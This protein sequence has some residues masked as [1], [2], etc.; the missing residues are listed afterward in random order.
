MKFPIIATS[1]C[2]LFYSCAGDPHHFPYTENVL[3]EGMVITA[4]TAHGILSI[5]GDTESWRKFSNEGWTATRRLIARSQRWNGSLGL[6]DPATTLFSPYGRLLVEEGRLFFDSEKDALRYLAVS[7]DYFQYVFNESGLVIG[8]NIDQVAGHQ[9]TR[10]VQLW[11]IYIQGRKPVALRGGDDALVQVS[12]GNS[13]IPET[14]AP[15]P[16][17]IGQAIRLGDTEYAP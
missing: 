14:A 8:L 16:A 17:P 13:P 10:S 1:T 15:H 7:G 9:P 12:G 6:Y 5:E 3:S 4:R 2:F 11:Q